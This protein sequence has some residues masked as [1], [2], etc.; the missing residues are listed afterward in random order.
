MC[1]RSSLFSY[2]SGRRQTHC[3]QRSDIFGARCER[4]KTRRLSACADRRGWIFQSPLLRSRINL[5]ECV[6]CRDRCV[7]AITP[8]E[9][10]LAR[11]G[12]MHHVRAELRAIDM[13]ATHKEQSAE[14][15][16]AARTYTHLCAAVMTSAHVYTL[17]GNYTH[18]A[19]EMT[20][21][22]LKTL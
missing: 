3:V 13:P 6:R 9:S 20:L 12:Q 10:H 8:A 1:R 4:Q 18:A 5:F 2:V 17:K 16:I 7:H 19:F 22:K 11:R 21:A 15:H 14:S